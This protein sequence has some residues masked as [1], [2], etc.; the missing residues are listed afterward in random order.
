[1][2]FV[3]IL[4][5]ALLIFIRSN[6]KLKAMTLKISLKNDDLQETIKKKDTLFKIITH[7]LTSPFQRIKGLTTLLMHGDASSQ[8]RE[9]VSH[10]QVTME[11]AEENIINLIDLRGL[12][13]REYKL[14]P[15]HIDFQ[16]L[17]HQLQSTLHARLAFKGITLSFA[18]GLQELDI[19]TD[20]IFLKRLIMNLISN[21]IEY[22]PNG[23]TIN[24]EKTEKGDA[25]CLI[26]DGGNIPQLLSQHAEELQEFDANWADDS[27]MLVNYSIKG[28]LVSKYAQMLD[29]QIKPQEGEYNGKSVTI[30]HLQFAQKTKQ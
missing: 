1:M 25:I 11:Q 22:S 26:S 29:I 17:T 9:T 6:Q 3:A 7:D 12:E 2:L 27:E 21:A 4:I 23:S 10:I 16:Q 14:N 5:V 24:I 18:K 20:Y 28:S 13:G 15:I 30:T 8:N 19:T